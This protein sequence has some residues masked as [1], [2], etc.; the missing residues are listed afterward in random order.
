MD[1]SST[2]PP[3]SL[4]WKFFNFLWFF[5]KNPPKNFEPLEKFLGKPCL[6]R[7]F[8]I[9]LLFMFSLSSEKILKMKN[10][11]IIFTLNNREILIKTLILHPCFSK[12][13]WSNYNF[14]HNN[15]SLLHISPPPSSFS[16][17][18]KLEIVLNMRI[19]RILD[20]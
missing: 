7:C 8:S 20:K 5:G 18:N 13:L 6:Y 14:M 4:R 19:F 17:F 10:Q 9:W 16:Y 11:P 1:V 15:Y 3:P 2:P 12:S